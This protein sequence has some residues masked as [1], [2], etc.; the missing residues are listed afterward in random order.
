[1]K[2]TMLSIVA[3][4]LVGTCLGAAAQTPFPPG[5]KV[6]IQAVTQASPTLPQYTRVEQPMLRDGLAKA[7]NGR[8]EVILSTWPE[9]NVTGPEVLRLVRTGQVDMAT[10]P[11]TMVSG[12]V[13]LLDGMDLAGMNMDIRQARRVA[14]AMMPAANKELQRLGIK[15]VA[16]FPFTAQMFYCNK[17]VT[18]L[19]D[20]KGLKLRTAG[21]WLEMS[22]DL[23]AAPVT[24]A[25]GDV[26]PMLVRGAID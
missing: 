20:L 15:L 6:V 3:S 8:V 21:A 10:A 4:A 22:K 25:A 16:T 13:P 5:P 12:D 11:L 18:G 2:K 14:D 19:A 26:F 9:R 23:G 17:P 1:M 7:T 24:T